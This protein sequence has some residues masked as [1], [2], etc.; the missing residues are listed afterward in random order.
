MPGPQVEDGSAQHVASVVGRE[1]K[2]GRHLRTCCRHPFELSF[3][4]ESMRELQACPPCTIVIGNLRVQ[5]D[6]QAAMLPTG[7]CSVCRP[8][9]AH[10][11]T[12]CRQKVK[13]SVNPSTLLRATVPEPPM[14][15]QNL[16]PHL[17][18]RSS[19]VMLRE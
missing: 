14:R 9:P 8:Q 15:G 13:R 19:V 12:T 11:M 18:K 3:F 1:L 7:S 2:P 4:D 16:M 6:M 5:R 10:L 17:P